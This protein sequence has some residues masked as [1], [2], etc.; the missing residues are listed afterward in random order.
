MK[1]LLLSTSHPYKSAGLV[2]LDLYNG[3][4]EIY[5]NEVKM[6]VKVW[7]NYPDK[8]IISLES[9]F[10]FLK[11]K[12]IRKI[13]RILRISNVSKTS[14]LVKNPDYAFQDFDHTITYFNTSEILKKINFIPEVIIVLFA[15]N[16]ISIKNIYEL[17]QQTKA[18]IY[19]FLMD[20][21]PFTGGCHY[22]WDCKGYLK[23]CGTCPGL[24]S[25]DPKDQT[26]INWRFK[27]EYI[28][29]ISIIPIAASEWQWRQLN[30]SS[31]FSEKKRVKI[32][33][34]TN[35][36]QFFPQNKII[37]KAK[38]LIQ[39]DKKVIFLGAANPSEKRK[40]YFEILEAFKILS[41]KLT[42]FQKANILIIIAGEKNESFYNSI[43]FDVRILGYLNHSALATVYQ[44]ADIF[45]NAS[46]EDS[47]PTMIN[48]AIM[49]GTPVVA[50][51]MGVALD[52]VLTGVTGYLAKLKDPKDLCNGLIDLLNLTEVEYNIMS[53]NCRELAL[54]KFEKKNVVAEFQR[55]I[56][57]TI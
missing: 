50:Y 1:I 10:S 17:N 3:L 6:L 42:T 47:G 54:A 34:P 16:F 5:G 57:S 24:Y 35:S 9:H 25:T 33:S 38:L 39:P 21:A 27:K 53:K 29:N 56:E 19:Q 45:L 49:S 23:E 26:N 2:S 40:G 41:D 36:E 15:Q 48:Q 14:S 55:L 44:A 13:K 7:G 28:N 31:L 37:A 20:M 52:L 32:L 51:E 11:V 22:A 30:A 8:N 12:I 43:S 46:I 18:K 4:K